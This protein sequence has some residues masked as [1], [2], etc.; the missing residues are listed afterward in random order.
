MKVIWIIGFGKFGSMAVDRLERIYCNCHFVL[1]DPVNAR[2][3]KARGPNR[4]L[5]CADGVSYL[6]NNLYS[7]KGPDWIIPALPVHLFAQWIIAKLKSI[8]L[9]RIQTP[10]PAMKYLPNFIEGKNGDVYVSHA[11]F[12]C[13][14]D[15]PE[16]PETCYVTGQKRKRNM[17]DLL[18]EIE[19]AEF[20]PIV[21]RSY[22]IAPGVGG[23]RP[24]QLLQALQQVS[25]T[26]TGVLL[27]TAC[28]CHGVITGL[29]ARLLDSLQNPR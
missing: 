24:E 27:C 3:I 21:V 19:V 25:M 28:R 26:T 13:P 11:D 5:E 17:Y 10:I 14:D 6:L 9:E 29:K 12:I 8:S 1:V 15:C 22:Q 16:P 20:L 2:L 18:N 7:E 4:T 23:Y